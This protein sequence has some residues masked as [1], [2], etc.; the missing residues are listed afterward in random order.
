MKTAELLAA[1]AA[2]CPNG[3]S[4]D[5]MAVRLLRQKVQ[6]E[7]WQVEDLKAEMFQ[8]GNGLWF[9][10]E[11]I[12]DDESQLVIEEQA[13]EWLLEH[14]CFSVERLFKH[15]FSIF[16]HIAS[17]EDCAAYW[18]YLDFRVSEWGNAGDFCYL[19]PPNLDDHLVAISET[20]S[21]WLEGENGM[22]AFN[23]IEQEL[24]HLS[25][26]ALES[27]RALLLPE[28]YVAKIGGVP[29]WCSTEAIPLP[30]DF[31]E[32]MTTVVD[33]L[34][35]LGKRVSVANLEFALNLFYRTHFREE[36]ALQDKDTFMRICAK[37]Y[38]GKNKIFSSNKKAG[39]SGN[40]VARLSKRRPN[41]RFCNIGVP[42]GAELFFINDN[43]IRCTVHDKF[44]Q[45]EYDGKVWA[46]SKLAIH[47]LGVSSANGF[48]HFIYEDETLWERRLRLERTG[49]K[50][51]YQNVRVLPIE[52]EE[53]EGEI[54]GLEGRPLM[55]STWRTFKSAGTNPNVAE[56]AM[57]LE[58]GES[59]EN[60]AQENGLMVSTV[61]EYIKNRR[62]Y[63][64]VC[65]KNGI[66]PESSQNV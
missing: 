32:K 31:S 16:R 63:F 6:F 44:N 19:P 7:D 37:H 3:I 2:E 61:K 45:V 54:I 46:I 11:M 55:P 10:R 1:L 62:R 43:N 39:A 38:Q 36:Y 20:I 60:I 26:D 35:V 40:A 15:F 64:D 29:C 17:P 34:V 24:P 9:T 33:T 41:T 59:E 27:I 42:V 18:R 28:V 57:R 5:P 25:A 51:D 14:G 30:E 12:L 66:V 58:H 47:L 56:W 53:M 21:E 23:E 48:C 8:L 22:L 4:F 52:E 50:D 65:E 49:N 13:I